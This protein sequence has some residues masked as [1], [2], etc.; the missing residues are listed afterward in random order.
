MNDYNESLKNRLMEKEIVKKSIYEYKKKN[1]ITVK[2]TEELDK[3]YQ[4]KLILKEQISKKINLPNKVEQNRPSITYMN[5][6]Q[7]HNTLRE[8]FDKY[9]L[10]ETDKMIEQ[11]QRYNNILKSLSELI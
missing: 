6:G 1:N 4:E 3:E 10:T 5:E 11:K 9:S 7:S 2:T 8:D